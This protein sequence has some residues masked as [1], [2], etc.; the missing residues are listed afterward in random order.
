MADTI[1]APA[2]APPPGG[3][4]ATL[5]TFG[6]LAAA[7]GAASCCA[8]PLLF[9][10]LGLGTAWLG[11]IAL[12]AAPHRGVL[13]AAAA[14]C[15]AGGAVLLW[16]QRAAAAACTPGTACARPAVRSMT[17]AGLLLGSVLLAL[18]YAIA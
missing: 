12:L 13:L 11:G 1:K 7:F 10:S 2:A 6:G 16:R 14:V 3:A 9:A 18:G 17:V 8:L 15:L 5:L 4:A